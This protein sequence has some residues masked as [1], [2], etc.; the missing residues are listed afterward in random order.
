MKSK[1]VSNYLIVTCKVLI[2]GSIF[3]FFLI[4]GG[5]YY[6][7]NYTQLLEKGGQLFSVEK[8]KKELVEKNDLEEKNKELFKATEIYFNSLPESIGFWTE[9]SCPYLGLDNSYK[10][11]DGYYVSEEYCP[12][13]IGTHGGCST[14]KMSRIILKSN[15]GLT[16]KQSS[17]IIKVTVDYCSKF[18]NVDLRSGQYIKAGPDKE[19]E[20]FVECKPTMYGNSFALFDNEN[21]EWKVL[22]E[23]SF[24]CENSCWN[25]KV[26]VEDF[27]NDGFDEITYST[28]YGDVDNNGY[29]DHLIYPTQDNKWFYC[30]ET[31]P[32]D[33]SFVK[34]KCSKNSPWLYSGNN[35]WIK[36]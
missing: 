23:D 34:M 11:P 17:E 22:M 10:V 18:N 28:S 12:E 30:S 13:E 3:L 9:G 6:F 5:I 4:I 8:Q 20:I 27:N 29:Y 26:A 35:T 7:K 14:C 25:D 36:N 21:G 19:K 32:S 1:K 2:I 15:L 16:S 24:D 31:F 33:G